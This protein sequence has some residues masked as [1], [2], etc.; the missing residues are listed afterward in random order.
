MQHNH[1]AQLLRLLLARLERISA[2]SAWAHR[3]SGIRGGLMR[4]LESLET[5][6][7]VDQHDLIL[8]LEDAFQVLRSAAREKG[9]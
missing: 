7:P 1:Q 2:D 4:D 3:A 5:G 8:D 9:I 6:Q